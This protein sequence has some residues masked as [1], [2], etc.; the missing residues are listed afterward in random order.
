[1]GIV[2]CI[3]CNITGEKY[4]GSTI[5]TLQQRMNSHKSKLNCSCKQIIL[6]NDYDIYKLGDYDTIRQDLLDEREFLTR[7]FKEKLEDY[8]AKFGSLPEKKI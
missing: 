8:E 6:R 7:Y 1:M 2:Y 3:V 4:Y 5:L